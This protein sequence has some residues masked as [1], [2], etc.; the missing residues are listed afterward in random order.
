MSIIS[1]IPSRLR[2]GL[3]NVV[4]P[5]LPSC[6]EKKISYRHIATSASVV[7]EAE[8]LIH[9]TSWA[10]VEISQF[11]VTGFF[12]FLEEAEGDFLYL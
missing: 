1:R 12:P 3:D 4:L 5:F 6:D 9:S 10:T 8:N 11:L 2:E 7:P